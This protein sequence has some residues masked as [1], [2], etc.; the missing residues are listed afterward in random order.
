LEVTKAAVA[1]FNGDGKADL[2]LRHTD[3]TVQA[4][5]MNGTAVLLAGDLNGDSKADMLWQSHGRHGEG[6][7][8]GRARAPE[9]GR[10]PLA[11]GAA[12]EMRT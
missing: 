4:W 3:G 6:V 2:V 9:P 7:D 12:A 5:L 8:P 10:R 11:C 1:D